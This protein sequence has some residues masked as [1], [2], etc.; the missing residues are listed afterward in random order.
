MEQSAE[1]YEHAAV[2]LDTVPEQDPTGASLTYGGLAQAEADVL[3]IR[4]RRVL[5]A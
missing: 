3:P 1:T 4:P 5:G 2:L